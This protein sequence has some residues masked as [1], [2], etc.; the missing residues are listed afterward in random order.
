MPKVDLRQ[1][2]VAI[3]PPSASNTHVITAILNADIFNKT[4]RD[5]WAPC[6]LPADHKPVHYLLRTATANQETLSLKNSDF[7]DTDTEKNFGNTEFTISAQDLERLRKSGQIFLGSNLSKDQYVA[8]VKLFAN[9]SPNEVSENIY[10]PLCK[11]PR[12]TTKTLLD[13]IKKEPKKFGFNDYADFERSQFYIS[14][15][16]SI[17]TNVIITK[18]IRYIL[19]SNYEL[20]D[21]KNEVLLLNTAG[22][23]FQ[24]VNLIHRYFSWDYLKQN[25]F[26]DDFT[27]ISNMFF[28]DIA[29]KEILLADFV[30]NIRL[31]LA[32]AKHHNCKYYLSLAIGLGAFLI[33][34]NELP[35]QGKNIKK[36]ISYLYY[37]TLFAALNKNDHGIE[38]FIVNVPTAEGAKEGFDLALQ[39]LGEDIN[40]NLYIHNKNCKSVALQLNQPGIIVENASDAKAILA[41]QCK[42]VHWNQEIENPKSPLFAG[43][44]MVYCETTAADEE[45]NFR[46]NPENIIELPLN[47]L[48]MLKLRVSDHLN[49][50]IS[51]W[52]LSLFSH[53]H[54]ARTRAVLAAIQQADSAEKIRAILQL[55]QDL[56]TTADLPDAPSGLDP[57]W[58]Q[59]Q[60]V[61]NF[62]AKPSRSGFFKAITASLT[63]YSSQSPALNL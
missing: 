1:D 26:P 23:D 35:D 28:N 58:A 59:A 62:P 16:V 15:L 7:K 29:G 25:S 27:N 5:G 43:E 32:V 52:K 20:T 54:N 41:A 53:H 48:P 46:M 63:E 10:V 4:D 30:E 11:L 55:Q 42:G 56:M 19:G 33:R 60:F 47:P 51:W 2:S 9:L 17:L 14:P 45:P 49:K 37:S 22:F 24:K 3:P 40:L 44:E 13:E 39:E 34:F 57:R 8:L 6:M 50:Y 38:H 36:Y 61:K 18:T 31:K 21:G 12:E